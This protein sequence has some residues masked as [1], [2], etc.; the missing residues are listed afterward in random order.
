MALVFAGVASAGVSIAAGQQPGTSGPSIQPAPAAE[1]VRPAPAGSA[2]EALRTL[3]YLPRPAAATRPAGQAGDA[4]RGASAPRP[5]PFSTAVPSAGPARAA[6][7]APA[8]GGRTPAPN[9]PDE[10][11]LRSAGLRDPRPPIRDQDGPFTQPPYGLGSY[12][13][14]SG[15][16]R[17]YRG[18]RISAPERDWSDYVYFGGRPSAYGYGYND[19][20]G[21]GPEG[22]AYRFGFNRGYY[23]GRF[24][25]NNE[26]T[27]T[28]IKQAYTS[29]DR[30]LIAFREGQYREAAD[31]FRLAA[32]T[33]QGD[34][35]PKIYAGHAL[36]ATGRYREAVKF[37][38]AALERQPRIAY[39]NYDMRSDYRRRE[40]FDRQ[41]AALR[42]ALR[43]APRDED[44]LF[45]LGYVLYFGGQRENAYYEFEKLVRINPRDRLAAQLMERCQPPDVVVSAPP[46]PVRDRRPQK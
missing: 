9:V 22:Q 17:G 37:L 31:A 43:L 8:A 24:E 41:L 36:F 11:D 25:Q 15:I 28:L 21:D 19:Y 5:A 14:F 12:W 45:M 32:D 18:S 6:Q 35:A 7:T 39:L 44:R 3:Y 33:N 20:Y 26:R 34:P 38:R 16:G 40:D 42:E 1:P 4:D 46:P 2:Q 30:G 27:E 23:R 10:E 13:L 29:M